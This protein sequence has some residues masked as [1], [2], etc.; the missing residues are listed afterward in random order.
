M[1]RDL[2][3]SGG[4]ASAVIFSQGKRLLRVFFCRKLEK[5]DYSSTLYFFFITVGDGNLYP[6]LVLPNAKS[7]PASFI[8]LEEDREMLLR[9]ER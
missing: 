7:Q 3:N 9:G 2:H 5:L 4:P 1:T 6:I 8:G